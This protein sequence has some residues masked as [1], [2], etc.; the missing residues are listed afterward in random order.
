MD[1]SFDS[2]RHTDLICELAVTIVLKLSILFRIV[3]Q[4]GSAGSTFLSGLV[5]LKFDPYGPQ[6]YSHQLVSYINPKLNSIEPLIGIQSG[7]TLIKIHGENFIIGNNH[8]TVW[9][10]SQPC[11]ILSTSE[12]KIECE[13]RSFSS[14][15]V[16]ENQP[17]KIL[18]DRQTKLIYDQFF[19]IVP[20]PILYSF[21][22]YHQYK[23]FKS[24]GHRITILGENLNTIQNIQL[25]FKRQIFVSPIFHNNTH[26]I[27]LTPSI[28]E[29]NLN[30]Q[31][32]IEMTIYLDN[33]NETSS[34]IYINDPFICELEPLL[35]TYTNRLVIQGTNLTAIGHTKHEILVYIG[36]DLCT[37]IHLQADKLI[38]QPP[39]HRPQKYSKTN[40]LCYSSQYPAIIVSIDNIHTH[41]GFMMYPKKIIILGKEFLY[42][43]IN[44]RKNLSLLRLIGGF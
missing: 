34:L 32:T 1:I 10:G 39:I 41:V 35:Q 29:L 30:K 28:R 44:S 19:T 37:V 6:I 5:R 9:I 24:G 18:F 3:C 16:N 11:Q 31:Q 26:L 15:M 38:C 8:I 36:C 2:S 23:S 13:T 42:I 27:F 4:S 25:E 7:G 33:L 17:I 40:R 20:N 12:V 22:K 43:L 21:D 14:S